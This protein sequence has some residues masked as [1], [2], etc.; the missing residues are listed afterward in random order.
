MLPV[1]LLSL[2]YFITKQVSFTYQIPFDGGGGSVRSIISFE[3]IR[4]G[5]NAGNS[6]IIIDT[7][8]KTK[9]KYVECYDNEQ[10]QPEVLKKYMQ[11]KCVNRTLAIGFNINETDIFSI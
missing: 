5:K 3:T 7:F 1:K 6:I 11:C 8:L 2:L 10:I 9:E 4:H